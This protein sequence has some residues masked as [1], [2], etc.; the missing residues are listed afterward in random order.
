MWRRLERDGH[1]A[2][3]GGI[4]RQYGI[5][6]AVA[7]R[8]LD[9]LIAEME[10]VR[11][12]PERTP[13][14]R[15][16][17]PTYA[18]VRS[19]TLPAWLELGKAGAAAVAVELGLRLL[20]LPALCDALGIMLDFDDATANEPDRHA[21]SLDPSPRYARRAWAVDRV[22]ARS[23]FPDTCL[24]RALVMGFFLR[25]EQPVLRIGASADGDFIAHAWIETRTA[26]YLAQPGYATFHR[27]MS[28]FRSSSP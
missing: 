28:A 11:A 10:A 5:S 15:H 23:P 9:A 13:P 20:S 17:L 12:R 27:T 21:A 14:R 1:E 3:V 2:A 25:V 8:D 26:R 7:R 24:R 4:S 19:L 16:S 22:F 6:S 18:R